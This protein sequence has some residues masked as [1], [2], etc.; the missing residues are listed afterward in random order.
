MK[1]AR[2]LMQLGPPHPLRGLLD[3]LFEPNDH[4]GGIRAVF[5]PSELD[6]TTERVRGLGEGGRAHKHASHMAWTMPG[7]GQQH[8]RAL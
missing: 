1:Q 4:P 6:T 8:F 2:S 5:P 3:S 7:Y